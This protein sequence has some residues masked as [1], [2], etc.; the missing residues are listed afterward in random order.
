MISQKAKISG[1]ENSMKPKERQA[2]GREMEREDWYICSRVWEEDESTIVASIDMS[3]LHAR[4][5]QTEYGRGKAVP[6]SVPRPWGNGNFYFLSFE[7][8]SESLAA[9]LEVK[10]DL[11]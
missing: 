9:M 1:K 8:L 7:E 11:F 3:K 5:W 10:S 4:V 2:L 6:V